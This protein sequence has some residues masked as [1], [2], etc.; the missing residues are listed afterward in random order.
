MAIPYQETWNFESLERIGGHPASPD[1]S[2]EIIQTDRG[3]ALFLD[4]IGDR[5]LVRGN[6]LKDAAAFTV[7]ILFKPGAGPNRANEPRFLH[8]QDP[9]DPQSKRLMV[10]IRVNEQARWSLD[11]FLL[12]DAGDKALLDL[13]K[14]HPTDVWAH[15]AVTY[16]GR[17]LRTYVNGV[18][19]LSGPLAHEARIL[20]P[21]AIVSVGSRMNKVH[22]LFGTIHSIRFTHA[23]LTVFQA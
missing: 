11:A 22:W 19:E 8:I 13:G 9:D 21:G 4:G 15:A 16:D 5:L 2:P 14:T 17:A 20:D 1:G 12:T 7:E 6:P 23:A 10:E 3:P 18:E